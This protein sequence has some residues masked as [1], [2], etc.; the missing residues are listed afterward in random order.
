MHRKKRLLLAVVAG[1]LLLGAIPAA[2]AQADSDDLLWGVGG[3]LLG[4]AYER[5]QHRR[6]YRRYYDRGYD[7]DYRPRYRRRYY[8]S[9]SYYRSDYGYR[10][11]YRRYDRYYDPCY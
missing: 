1:V 9:Y 3:F 11:R 5:G 2:P 6:H 10:P 8:D 7:Y 4:Q